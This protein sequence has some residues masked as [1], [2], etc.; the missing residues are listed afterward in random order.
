MLLVLGLLTG[1]AQAQ[2]FPERAVVADA[3]GVLT[4]AEAADLRERAQRLRGGFYVITVP[5][6]GTPPA[7]YARA[8]ADAWNLDSGDGLL[9]VAPREQTLWLSAGAGHSLPE[10]L[11]DSVQAFLQ[12]DAY[13]E[14]LRHLLNTLATL[15]PS[16]DRIDYRNLQQALRDGARA[17]GQTVQFQG[18]VLRYRAGRAEVL[19]PSRDRV[20][21]DAPDARLREDAPYT[22]TV[23]LTRQRP[24]TLVLLRA[25]RR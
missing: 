24:L 20:F 22:F 23:R 17:E 4:R 25:D 18:R 1:P 11:A 10:A 14:G 2:A 5:H 9:V 7:D 6:L 16:F 19:L 8:L 3:A 21:L 12:Q 15:P 13:Y